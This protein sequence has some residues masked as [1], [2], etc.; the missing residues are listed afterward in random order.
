ML[1]CEGFDC[2]RALKFRDFV[3]GHNISARISRAQPVRSR[4]DLGDGGYSLN[5]QCTFV[6]KRALLANKVPCI[7]DTYSKLRKIMDT[8]DAIRVII[9]A[10]ELEIQI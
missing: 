6:R 8:S 2:H 9:V 1:H 10:R 4:T 7:S 5:K 3:N